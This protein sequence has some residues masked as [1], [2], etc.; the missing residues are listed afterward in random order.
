MFENK[1]KLYYI[2]AVSVVVIIVVLYFSTK[3]R[4]VWKSMDDLS[5]R[6]EEQEDLLRKQM[7]MIQKLEVGWNPV[8]FA[9]HS[10]IVPIPT[11]KSTTQEKAV[12]R[13]KKLT[14]QDSPQR[15]AEV[16][17]TARKVVYT[18]PKEPERV[19]QQ[20]SRIESRPERIELINE[21]LDKNLDDELESE[22]AELEEEVN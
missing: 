13:N 20:D 21:D 3:L 18:A 1:E 11:P 17:L 7:E 6:I 15:P 16:V 2:V 22:L 8:S 5:R 12:K 14:R 9:P 4:S 10:S 19:L